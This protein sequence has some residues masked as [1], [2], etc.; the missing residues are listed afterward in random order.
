MKKILLLAACVLMALGSVARAD[1][2]KPAAVT[3]VG[4]NGQARYST[5]GKAWHPLVVGKILR[6]GAI[7]ETAAGSS[8]D[9][10]ISGTPVT[11]PQNMPLGTSSASLGMPQD[12][13][14]VGFQAY[15]PAVQQNVIHMDADSMMAVDKL[16]TVDTGNDSVSD[17]ELDL[18]A[19]S[20]FTNVKKMSASSQYIIK[21]P[22]GVAGIR[23]SA[24]SVN[25]DGTTKTLY[26][27][28]IVSFIGANG[29]PR[30]VVVHG[31]FSYNP[32]T[33]QVESMPPKALAALRRAG[34]NV[35]TLIAQV[36]TVSQDLTVVFISPQQGLRNPTPPPR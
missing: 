8:A 27:T 13:N 31:G 11:V 23:G 35:Q 17:T 30:V 4:V 28:I 7:I 20:V 26:G 36:I 6:Q 2:Q 3:V 34:Y 10:V 15:A 33:G 16:T 1:S 24:G 9:L 18:R 14:V 29:Q 22:D 12:P 32:K 21:L 5:D 25:S 19:G